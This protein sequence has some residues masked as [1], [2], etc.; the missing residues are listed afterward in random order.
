M[1]NKTVN[2][3]NINTQNNLIVDG[4][5]LVDELS[6]E[7]IAHIVDDIPRFVK[8]NNYADSFGFQWNHWDSNLSS[9]RNPKFGHHE[10]LIKRTN[11]DKL[12][13][14][15]KTII[16]C[17]AG[18]G[19]DTEVF[20]SLPFSEI[21]SFDLSNSINRSKKY[22]NDPRVV[23]SQA[24]IYEIPYPDEAF[25]F[26]FCHRVLQH[27]PDPI[28]ALKNICKKVKKGGSYLL[29]HIIVQK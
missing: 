19:D 22:I 23:L 8:L 11:F 15:D 2:F 13:L 28:L 4:E 29:T 7:V 18:G 24:S 10:V 25:D 9:I 17:G 14:K 3:I 26:V 1:K 27:T 6:G 21:H 20:C 5:N 12:D 16:E